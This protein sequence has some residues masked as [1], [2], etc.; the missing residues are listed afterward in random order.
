M[1]EKENLVKR[2]GQYLSGKIDHHI[3]R[4]SLQTINAKTDADEKTIANQ[5]RI[6]ID[7][8]MHKFAVRKQALNYD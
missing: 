2:L 3:L 6:A 5:V 4:S 7:E 8:V 1:E